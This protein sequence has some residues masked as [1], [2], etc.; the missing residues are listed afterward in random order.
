E[1]RA[2]G[3]ETITAGS[4][5]VDLAA[6]FDGLESAGIDRLMVEG[7]G[8]IIFSLFEANLVDELTLFVGSMVVGGRDAPTLA[9][10]EGFVDPDEFPE[11]SLTDVRRIDD[12]VL[13]SY[14]VA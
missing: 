3:A 9:D 7:G 10:G 13:L 6:A 4:D 8:E 12:G 1:L 14:D 5:R 2:A 11:L